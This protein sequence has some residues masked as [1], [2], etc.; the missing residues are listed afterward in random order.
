MFLIWLLPI[1]SGLADALSRGVIKLTKI[2]R[3]ILVAGTYF[4]T[5]PFWTIWL[6][7]S[8]VPKVGPIYWLYLIIHAPLLALATIF[9][10]EAHR[11]SEL[12][13]TAP[14]LSLT[15]AYLLIIAPIMNAGTP[16]FW[17]AIGVLVITIG[18]YIINTK[19]K[20]DDLWAPFKNLKKERGARLMFYVGIIFAFTASIDLPAIRNANMPFY[21]LTDHATVAVL[22]SLVAL[23]YWGKGLADKNELSPR[24]SLRPLALNGFL[25]VLSIVPQFAALSILQNA[26]YVIAGKRLGTIIFSVGLGIILGFIH[27]EHRKERD[28]LRYRLIGT[29]IMVLGMALIIF[30]GK[31]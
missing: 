26:P 4:F 31:E 24:G 12:T 13:K 20:Q 18:V 29:A 10:V 16:T 28:D 30:W 17:G 9:T 8:G 21:L 27:K 6:F 19:E 15:P 2:N 22:C 25:T 1:A 3:L 23:Y 11:S 5:L 7:W 14:Y